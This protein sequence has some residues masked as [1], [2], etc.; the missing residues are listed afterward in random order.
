[1]NTT[2]LRKCNAIYIIRAI[3]NG[4]SSLEDIA[5]ETEMSIIAVK[6]IIYD[7][8]NRSILAK[9]KTT[10]SSIGRPKIYF[11]LN[12]LLHSTIIIKND[13]Q[14][15]I[16]KYNI[17]GKLIENFTFPLHFQGLGVSGSLRM[18]RA[19]L[20]ENKS[21]KYN[22]STFL[23]GE[24]IENLENLHS[25]TKTNIH[26]LILDSL[27]D[28][29]LVLLAEINHRRYL[30]NHGKVKEISISSS[31]LYKILDIDKTIILNDENQETYLSEAMRLISLQKI[32]EKI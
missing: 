20:K 12:P 18:L 4:F 14:F 13:A 9:F 3:E 10:A 30:L 15:D 28:E 2:Y 26:Q 31:E 8:Y 29:D 21:N 16:R 11:E 1:M 7:L 32:E 22:L 5:N 6:K 24:S 17:Q 23:I 25:I 27:Y 19:A